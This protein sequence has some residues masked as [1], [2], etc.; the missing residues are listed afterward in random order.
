[1][2]SSCS[3]SSNRSNGI[4]RF[5]V[6]LIDKGKNGDMRAMIQT[7]NSLRVCGST[8]FGRV[9]HH[10]GGVRRHQGAVCVLREILVARRIQNIDAVSV[11]LELHHGRSDRNAPL[12]FNLHP[13]GD[14]MTRRLFPFDRARHGWIA[15]P[16]SRNFSVRVVLPAS[17]CEII[18]KVLLFSI[19]FTYL[20]KAVPPTAQFCPG[21]AHCLSSSGRPSGSIKKVYKSPV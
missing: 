8:P 18:A 11:V 5:A 21:A 19:S 10:D 16:Y 12:L 7:L 13:V 17:G 15:P 2:P 3:I 14:R 4:A 20:D 1:M 6:H 9:D